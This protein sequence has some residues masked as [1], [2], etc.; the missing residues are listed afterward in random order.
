MNEF[1]NP[2]SMLTL[3][4]A[5]AIVMLIAN[6]L[7]SQFPEL[8]FRWLAIALSFLIGL[9][10]FSSVELKLGHRVALWAF[11]SLIIFSVGVGTS[12]I[13]ANVQ[14]Q[15]APPVASNHIENEW[16]DLS[17]FPRA[18]AG[19]TFNAAEN[20]QLEQIKSVL[21]QQAELISNIQSENEKLRATLEKEATSAKQNADEPSPPAPAENATT[22]AEEHQR[23]EQQAHETAKEIDRLTLERQTLNQQLDKAELQKTQE[24]PVRIQQKGFFRIW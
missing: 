22:L 8:A 24:Q 17:F 12:N 21:S 2:K 1:L 13:A 20:A 16:P 11:N 10:V 19:A 9:I 23:A 4:A 15:P 14:R 18:Y 6:T 3:G 7:C 5:G